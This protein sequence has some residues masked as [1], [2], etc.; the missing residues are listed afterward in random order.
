MEKDI[1]T[2]YNQLTLKDLKFLCF[3]ARTHDPDFFPF[4]KYGST[5]N[6]DQWSNIL[7]AYP[8][9]IEVCDKKILKEEHWRKILREQPQLADYCPEKKWTEGIVSWKADYQPPKKQTRNDMLLDLIFHPVHAEFCKWEKLSAENW[10]LLLEFHPEF[11]SRCDISCFAP[12]MLLP[13]NLLQ[14]QPQWGKYFDISKLFN[15]GEFLKKNPEYEKNCKWENIKHQTWLYI[16]GSNPALLKYCD[17]RKYPV[18]TK[19]KHDGR[20]HGA[21]AILNS[22]WLHTSP[23]FG[24]QINKTVHRE[25]CRIIRENPVYLEKW[26]AYAA[27]LDQ[28]FSPSKH[29]LGYFLAEYPELYP[30]CD[31]KWLTS[32][33][34]GHLIMWHPE[35]IHDADLEIMT[36]DAW[37][38]ILMLHPEL[39]NSCSSWEDFSADEWLCLL[40][41]PA[42]KPLYE[43]II[44]NPCTGKKTRIHPHPEFFP[45][46]PEKI[47]K[48]WV[49]AVF[50]KE[51][52]KVGCP[53]ANLI[54]AKFKKELQ[55]KI[56][57][58]NL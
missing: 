57:D 31:K 47:Y 50:W 42:W 17:I 21:L 30:L 56:R 48:K 24:F 19:K 45:R 46:C 13:D 49:Y 5:I 40:C 12:K 4:V 39:A 23:R 34:W 41:G 2:A 35:M 36:S 52:L 14:L 27:S 25:I 37:C 51:L 33:D 1:E 44:T 15:P 54:P 53:V 26:N 18:V 7:M 22:A 38:N 3:D 10:H 9:L 28:D 8:H 43:N 11:I 29:E 6:P 55:E 16:L 20:F 58:K 32:Q